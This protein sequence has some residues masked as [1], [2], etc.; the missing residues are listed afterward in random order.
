MMPAVRFSTIDTTT[1]TATGTATCAASPGSM[2]RPKAKKN[3][4]ANASRRGSTSR[5][6]RCATALS[7]RTRPAMNAP[8]ASDTPSSSAM[9]ATRTAKPTK[10]TVSSSSSGVAIRRPTIVA[11][12]RAMAP[13]VSR[14]T[15]ATSELADC[16][17]GALCVAE[18]R[19]EQREVEREEDVLD[20]D[21]AEDQAALGVGEPVQL[22]QQLRDDRRR[23][24]ADRAGDHERLAGAPAEREPEHEA[25]AD[26]EQ[27]VDGADAEQRGR[28]RGDR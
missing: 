27:E 28:R 4:A 9:P 11:P 26:V 8:I 3:A 13:R 19:L 21:D 23:R 14:N 12:Q 18:H 16:V 10:H 25:A 5:S 15:N 17:G 24:D 1:A 6:I 7:A 22:D 20:D 2:V